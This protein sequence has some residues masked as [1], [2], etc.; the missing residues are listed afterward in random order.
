MKRVYEYHVFISYH[1]TGPLVPEWVRNHFRPRLQE[2][3]GEHIVDG[4]RIFHDDEIKPG[5]KWPQELRSA[6]SR[7][8]ILVVV[9]SPNYFRDEWCLAEWCSMAAREA[10]TGQERRHGLIYPVIFCDSKNFPDFAH[11]RRMRSLTDWNQ[12]G[13]QFEVTPAYVEFRRQIEDIAIELADLVQEVPPWRPDWPVETP[14]P[15]PPPGP[16]RLPRF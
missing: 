3:L 11:E 4:A 7:S 13:A 16:S 8:R 10:R 9:C 1:R 15:P 14:E 6:L 5:G 2:W 12:S